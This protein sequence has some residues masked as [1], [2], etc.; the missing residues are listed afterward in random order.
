LCCRRSVRRH[1]HALVR[2]CL[3]RARRRTIH[4][5]RVA[6][7]HGRGLWPRA[8]LPLLVGL[9]LRIVWVLGV[10]EGEVVLRDVGLAVAFALLPADEELFPTL[11]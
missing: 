9:L 11:A 6:V 7:V 8:V 4:G 1:L 3:G 2:V 5:R 10:V